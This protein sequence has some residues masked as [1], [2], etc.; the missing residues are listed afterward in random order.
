MSRKSVLPEK[1]AIELSSDEDPELG[2]QFAKQ[3][4]HII[5]RLLAPKPSATINID[6][7]SDGHITPRQSA[8]G[9]GK[10]SQSLSTPNKDLRRSSGW[11]KITKST[12]TN[13][14]SK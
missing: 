8:W 14:P 10:L 4:R 5:D 2:A 11:S 6:S 9:S 7:D 13:D 12:P 3:P 1:A